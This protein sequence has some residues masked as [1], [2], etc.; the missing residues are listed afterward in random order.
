MK[1]FKLLDTAILQE[2]DNENFVFDI[3]NER[4]YKLNKEAYMVLE[5][6]INEY[7]DIMQIY[8]SLGGN[9]ENVDNEDIELIK[10]F[11]LYAKSIGVIEEK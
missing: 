10:E 7:K 2:L 9:V 5:S 4:T 6:I 1:Q 11:I 3:Q 8:G